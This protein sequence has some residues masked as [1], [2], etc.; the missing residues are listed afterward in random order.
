MKKQITRYLR[1]GSYFVLFLMLM[2]VQEFYAQQITGKVVDENNLGVPGV[3]II[4]KGS[5]GGVSTDIDGNYKIAAKEGDFLV[6][7]F[8]GY[9]DQQVKVGTGS[10]VDVKLAS[11]LSSLDEVIVIGYGTTKKKDVTGAVS[12]VSAKSFADQPL[13]NAQE[14]LQGRAAGVIVTRSSGAPGAAVKVRVRGVN[15]ITGSNDPLV[16]VDGLIGG[17]LSALNPND[18]ASMDVLKDAS[19]TATYGVRGANG[20]IVITTKKGSGAGKLSVDYFTT[21]A[22]IP[23]YLPTLADNVGDFARIENVRRGTVFFTDAQIAEIEAQGGTDYQREILQTG[24]SKNLQISASGSEGK[25]KYFISGNYSN[26]EGSVITTKAQKYAVRS[27]IEAAINDKLKVGLNFF[28]NRFQNNNNFENFGSFQGSM[29]YKALTWDP[30]TPVYQSNG[31]FNSRSIRGIASLNQN[32]VMTLLGSDFESIEDLVN[33]TFNADYKITKDLTYNMV[34][35]TQVRN[36]NNQNYI[37]ETSNNIPEA[38]YSNNKATSYQFTNILTWHKEYGEHDVKVTGVQEYNNLKNIS[39]SYSGANISLPN[40]FYFAEFANA[41]SKN[42]ANNFAEQ[43]L[44]SLMLRG[45]YIF[46]DNL[47]ITGTI[48]RDESSVFREDNRVGYFPSAALAYSFND[49]LKEGFLSSLKLRVGWGNVGNQNVGPYATETSYN[50]INY[51]FDGA[52]ST[53]GVYLLNNG[54]PD[55]T[56]ETTSQANIGVDLGF[57]KG[58]G[59]VSLDV[60]KKLTSDLLLARPISGTNG[61]GGFSGTPVGVRNENV[62]EVSNKGIDISIGYDVI[63]KGNFKWDSNLTFTY[64]ENKV[65]ELYGSVT[66]INGLFTAPGGQARV[67]NVIEKGQPLGQLYGATFLGTWKTTDAIPTKPGATTPI[68]KPGEAK[69]A[70]NSNY[71]VI[72]GAIGNGTPTTF[73]GW[74]NSFSFKNWSCNMFFQYAGGFDVYNMTQAGINGGAGDA[75]SFLASEQVNYW[76]AGNETDV[77]TNTIFSN[78]SK[79]LEKGDFFRLS[80]LNVGYTFD[81][82]PGI[83]NA[84]MKLYFSGQNLLLITDYSGYDPENSTTSRQGQGTSDVTAGIN[85]GAFPTTRNYTFGLKLDF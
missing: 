42:Y 17:D 10:S 34:L 58:R 29:I 81:K 39:N 24:I 9:Q 45:E 32:P 30:T 40:G 16:V 63:N 78:S 15:S 84:K 8:V 52:S 5:K 56:W 83:K 38:N 65:E 28:G 76:R 79:F 21:I 11:S 3:N 51:T 74:N 4:K 36:N 75:R 55:L 43:E 66:T 82:V 64:V 26:T 44:R 25:L 1:N 50:N 2:S 62:G 12:Q 71:D 18:I 54:N 61:G 23:K 31:E 80:N 47:Y 14:A 35:G 72:F 60:Y 67:L 48:R 20:V 73:I 19:A 53:P 33:A 13:I 22:T 68:A 59:N 7:S 46:H 41:V 27:N 70:I 77:P 85:V 6:F 57:Q 69:Y 37:N 49:M